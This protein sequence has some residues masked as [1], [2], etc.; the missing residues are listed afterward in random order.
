M[1]FG[2]RHNYLLRKRKKNIVSENYRLNKMH[3]L[4]RKNDLIGKT[5]KF[6]KNFDEIWQ[7]K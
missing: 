4:S 1:K 2:K 5:Q 7:E 3:I 6:L